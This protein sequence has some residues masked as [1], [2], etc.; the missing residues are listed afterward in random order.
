[1]S[2]ADDLAL[3]FAPEEEGHI[4]LGSGEPWKML[5][6]DDEPSVHDVTK[7][8]LAN[9]EFDGRPLVF[10]HAYSAAEARQCL[11]EHDNIALAMIDVVMESEHAGLD[12]VRHIREV[13]N[14][15][16]IRIVLRTGQPGQAPERT[17][18]RDYDI[19]DYKEKTELSAN[20]LYS[21]VFTSLRSFRDLVALDAN[22][23]G[24]ERVIR[25]SG[26][27]FRH[28][29]LKDFIQG[30][31]EQL[32]ALL[33]LDNDSMYVN[34]DTLA[35]EQDPES[36]T[37][38]AATGKFAALVGKEASKVLAPEVFA[39]ISEA[40]T[41]RT[42]ITRDTN[43]VGYFQATAG[44]EDVLFV[45]SS[46]PFSADSLNLVRLFC[47]NVSIAYANAILRDE[48]EG[49]Q[50]DIVHMLGEA[51]ETRSKETG[52]HVHR[53]AEY[54]RLIALGVGFSEREAEI[55]RMAAP[56]HDFGK[57][58]VPDHILHKPG[59]LDADEWEIMKTHASLGGDMLAKSK[60]EILQTAAI[61]S[62]QHHEKW[63]GSGYPLGLRGEDIHIFGRISAVADVFDALG[64]RR[65]YKDPWS[66]DK[67]FSLFAEQRG[68]HFDPALV[69]WM[70]ENREALLAVR[71]QFPD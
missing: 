66:L 46:R 15:H 53:V 42:S 50:R 3:S 7:L 26:E 19:N 52:Q 20:K 13:A 71:D 45:S 2:E 16:L 1:M 34:C 29:M 62:S 8:A 10:L 41:Q 31:L 54:C 17:V 12:L 58:G 51:I 37:I 38:L 25:A 4:H 60:R 47:H 21:T 18:I 33:Y 23:Q 40:L 55:L 44:R 14:N 56:L 49:T 27:M 65:C 59:R 64:S 61:I 39:L 32:I 5:I 30:V 43:Y 57:I 70:L 22:R 68:R 9:F 48:I 69:D 35:L 63:D 36:I 24:L 67:I 6:V 11:E 28:S